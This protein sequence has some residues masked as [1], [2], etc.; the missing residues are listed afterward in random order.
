MNILAI[1]T[2]NQVLGVAITKDGEL[3]GELMTNINKDHSSRLMPAIVSLM[4]SVE[5]NPESI[6]KVVVA[7]GPGSYT[8][9]RIGITT[10]KTFAWALN[11]PIDTVSSL[12][13][14]AYNGKL[15]NGYICPL[16]D[17]RRKTVFTS[18]YRSEKG[19]LK[20]VESDCN[21]SLEEWFHKLNELQEDIMFLSPHL[22]K[23]QS[24]ILDTIGKRAIIPEQPYHLT[25]PGNLILL[26]ERN[27]S[28]AVHTVSPNY[29]R[30]TEA[31]A[32][33]LKKQE[34]L[35]KNG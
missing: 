27:E 32:K 8:G 13:A 12:K 35:K 4:E 10:A 2:S 29:L 25:K 34:E 5:M 3:V 33:L 31:E 18:L 16:F 20:E 30:L 26:S 9:T 7:D 23:L 11:I 14:L 22:D 19:A 28:K 21:I 6:E 15:F 17:A 24:F 1:D